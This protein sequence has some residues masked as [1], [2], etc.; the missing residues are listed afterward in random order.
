MFW[1]V[2]GSYAPKTGIFGG[3]TYALHL[4]VFRGVAEIYLP[5]AL[6][7]KQAIVSD[8]LVRPVEF[9]EYRSFTEVLMLGGAR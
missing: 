2:L 7:Y 8:S 6:V 9:P 4:V 1:A 3:C 5:A